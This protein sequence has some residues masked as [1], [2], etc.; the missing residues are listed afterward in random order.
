MREIESDDGDFASDGK[1]DLLLESGHSER[2]G[3]YGG[4]KQ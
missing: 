4:A 3:E 1:G 2:W